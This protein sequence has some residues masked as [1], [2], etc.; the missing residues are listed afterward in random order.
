M[1]FPWSP[2]PRLGTSG[3]IQP[4]KSAIEP[5]GKM[6]KAISRAATRKKAAIRVA[7]TSLL[8]TL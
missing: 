1:I 8:Y 5:E 7:Y 6:N 3:L 2:A 4:K